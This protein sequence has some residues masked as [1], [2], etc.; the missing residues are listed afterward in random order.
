M[1]KTSPAKLEE[2]ATGL[3]G[4]FSKGAISKETTK[5]SLNQLALNTMRIADINTQML[6]KAAN[7]LEEIFGLH[8]L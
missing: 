7:S 6:D 2:W 5:Q 1:P 3:M 4:L 8:K